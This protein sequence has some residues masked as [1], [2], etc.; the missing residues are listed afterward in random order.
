MSTPGPR[1]A[2]GRREHHVVP[3]RVELGAILASAMGAATL[4]L[5]AC[6][7]LARDL[8][9]EFEVARW[10]IGALVTVNSLTGAVMSP[11]AGRLADRFGA[12]RSTVLT[13][14][15]ATLGLLGISL[16]PV[17]LVLAGSTIV[18]GI[19]Q[20]LTNPATN[21]VLSL[22]IPKG[23]RGLITGVKQSGVQ[24]GTFLAGVTMPVVAAAWGW[25]A[26]VAV[27]AVASLTALVFAVLRIPHDPPTTAEARS[28]GGR[29]APLPALV[30]RIAA[31]GF[32]LGTGGTAIVTYLPLFAEEHLG[33]SPVTAGRA[34]AVTGLFGVVARISWGRIAEVRLGART[35]LM[36]IALTASAAATVLAAST[37][38]PG[39]IWL[40]AALTGIS[41]SA[42]NSVGMLAIITE[43]PFEHAGRGSGVVL[44]GFL[45]GLSVGAPV[46]GWSVDRIGVY[47][48]GWLVVAGIF[49]LGFL[50]V[51]S[52]RRP[53]PVT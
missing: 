42:W 11:I 13:L 20:A 27:F 31:Y 10:Q 51:A 8:I 41:A 40:G 35:S 52:G 29:S 21:K 24:F 53:S 32:L 23:S 16:S 38:M 6:A 4:A 44:F 26:A 19:A 39:L 12:R 34:L 30:P 18:S 28:E 33:L 36:V 50:V 5:A 2:P 22:H 1:S 9:V 7:V 45:L 3:S 37:W 46:F 47:T 43:V 25:R 14:V 49:G 48:P 15:V 17:F